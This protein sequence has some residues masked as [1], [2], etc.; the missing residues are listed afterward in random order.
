MILINFD[1]ANFDSNSRI[2]SNR[3]E[4]WRFFELK[5]LLLDLLQSLF[6]LYTEIITK[7]IR[8]LLYFS[9]FLGWIFK[10]G[11]FLSSFLFFF[12]LV[13]VVVETMKLFFTTCMFKSILINRGKEFPVFVAGSVP[14]LNNI[15]IVLY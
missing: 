10:L 4:L 1:L 14:I 7:P 12:E 5:L 3:F 13:F 11:W 9:W 2:E 8:C 15:I 6:F